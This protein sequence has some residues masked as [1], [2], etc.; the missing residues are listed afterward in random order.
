MYFLLVIGAI[1]GAYTVGV[2]MRDNVTT[3]NAK[4]TLSESFLGIG[5]FTVVVGF[6]FAAIQYREGVAKQA[7]EKV[8]A[9]VTELMKSERQLSTLHMIKY[10]SS[11]HVLNYEPN[12][13]SYNRY[14]KNSAKTNKRYKILKGSNPDKSKNTAHYKINSFEVALALLP[15]AGGNAWDTLAGVSLHTNYQ[16]KISLILL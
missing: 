4:V 13:G 12:D 15:R 14:I 6:L 9:Q 5:P 7:K 1:I 11:E 8:Y 10:S 3:T 2:I 16:V